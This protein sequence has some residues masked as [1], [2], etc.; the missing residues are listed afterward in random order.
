MDE[1]VKLHGFWPSNY[2]YKV[3]W[4]LKLKGIK[5]EYIEEDLSNKSDLL[6]KYN[7]VYQKVPVL[8]HGGKP[9]PESSVILEYIEDTWPQPYPL[10][11]EDAFDRA[12]ARFWIN[13]GNEKGLVFYSFFKA[14]QGQKEEAAKQVLEVLKTLEEHGLGSKKF[15]GGESINAVDLSFG[16]LPY[17][18]ECIE[19]VL[20]IKVIESTSLPRL[21]SWL[22]NFK[23]EPLIKEN[24]PDG[25]KLLGHMKKVRASF[26]VD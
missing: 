7:P 24:C 1:E 16:F 3:I 17:W 18:F 21:H 8:V 5:Y 13:F 9:V 11:P 4:A 22:E 23:E 6:L 14:G 20:G 12:M 10:F 15:F 25:E 2:V 19:E 26:R